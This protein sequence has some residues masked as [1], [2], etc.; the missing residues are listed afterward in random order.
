MHR[1]GPNNLVLAFTDTGLTSEACSVP[2]SRAEPRPLLR[3][4]AAGL[5]AL[6]PPQQACR[7]SPAPGT[8]TMLLRWVLCQM[9][10]TSA[11]SNWG[12]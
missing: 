5:H 2:G 10:R 12:F 9:A 8:C 1:A 7:L 4:R 6:T 3:M 11:P